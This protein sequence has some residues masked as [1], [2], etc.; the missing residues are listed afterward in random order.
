MS[1]GTSKGVTVTG[2]GYVVAPTPAEIKTLAAPPKVI[3]MPDGVTI[4]ADGSY[5]VAPTEAEKQAI[6]REVK[7]AHPDMKPEDIINVTYT[8][9]DTQ[10]VIT[11]TMGDKEI[12]TPPKFV[13]PPLTGELGVSTIYGRVAVPVSPSVEK[14]AQKVAEWTTFIQP[15]LGTPRPE[16]VAELKEQT[17]GIVPEPLLGG[18]IQFSNLIDTYRPPEPTV[19]LFE[20][21]VRFTAEAVATAIEWSTGIPLNT[22]LIWDTLA[23]SERKTRLIID[24]IFMGVVYGRPIAR[25]VLSALTKSVGST[26]SRTIAAAAD[27]VSMAVKSGNPAK[28]RAA[29]G[30]LE[31]LGFAMRRQGVEGADTVIARSRTII[32]NADRV[33]ALRG[34]TMPAELRTT[35][36]RLGK[37]IDRIQVIETGKP[38]GADA[39]K[40]PVIETKGGKVKVATVPVTR[41]EARGFGLSAADIDGIFSKVGDNREAFLA[42]ARGLKAARLNTVFNDINR[43]LAAVREVKTVSVAHPGA[44]PVTV[45][46]RQKAEA[47]ATKLAGEQ[48]KAATEA[49]R[50]AALRRRFPSVKQKW[51]DE[52]A[53][54]TAKQ[55]AKPVPTVTQVTEAMP[56]KWQ[57]YRPYL[58]TERAKR[59]L[60]AWA[61][62]APRLALKQMLETNM[63][64]FAIATNARIV[65]RILNSVSAQARANALSQLSPATREAIITEN[66]TQAT[67]A[68]KVELQL[69]S[70][71]ETATDLAIALAHSLALQGQTATQ[72][73]LQVEQAL[74]EQVQTVT[75]TQLKTDLQTELETIPRIVTRLVTKVPPKVPV[76]VPGKV[77]PKTPPKTPPRVPPP[78]VITLPDGSG[79]ELTKE[80]RRG[81]VGWKQGFMY[82]LIWPPYG[83]NNIVNTRKPIKGIKYHTGPQSAYRS[84]TKI[85]GKIPD[86]I[87]RDMGIMDITITTP[88]TGK[89][90]M[91]FELDRKQKTKLT[92]GAKRLAKLRAKQ[93]A[94]RDKRRRITPSAMVSRAR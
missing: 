3:T 55:S 79:Q 85:G 62:M 93:K 45:A 42:E 91:R 80:E 43:Q 8:V 90:S 13:A 70:Q 61:E 67:A 72:I 58:A 89:P 12:V 18:I 9:P 81:A 27:R 38:L 22:L 33:A 50:Q 56:S 76:K 6:V 53:R 75:Q 84:I 36:K 78:V 23:P 88:K 47:A 5:L 54:V 16:Q 46:E 74:Q 19:G 30:E 31:E 44:K 41:E 24:G 65:A 20:K 4:S 15:F 71:T 10:K 39:L 64:A 60:Q 87:K 7:A 66:L 83:Q 63:L 57:L 82:K 2:E 59:I 92:P 17:K 14:I 32:R 28:I 40:K 37:D 51:I 49:A 94:R 25:G 48:S 69:Q 86:T 21:P 77:P 35:L 68:A 26:G 34:Q 29:A 1:N 52:M 11:V 73:K